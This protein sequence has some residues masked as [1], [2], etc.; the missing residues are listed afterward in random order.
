[1]VEVVNMFM[2][3]FMKKVFGRKVTYY[4][5]NQKD[6]F[7]TLEVYHDEGYKLAAGYDK[8]KKLYYMTLLG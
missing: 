8:Q 3:N 1:M 7:E 4:M 2:E 5:D 6:L